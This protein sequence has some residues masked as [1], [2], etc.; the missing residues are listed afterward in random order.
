M[1][2]VDQFCSRDSLVA[3][4]RE[5]QVEDDTVVDGQSHQHPDQVVLSQRARVGGREPVA[6]RLVVVHEHA[7]AGLV[8]AQTHGPVSRHGWYVCTPS[9]VLGRFGMWLFWGRIS[10]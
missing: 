1:N 2:I 4:V 9:G 7:V 8:T 10:P 6:A 5:S 3:D